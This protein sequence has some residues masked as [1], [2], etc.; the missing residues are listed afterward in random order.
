MQQGKEAAAMRKRALLIVG[1]ALMVAAAGVVYAHWTATLKVDAN[2]YTG[3]I[4]VHWKS[5]STDDDGSNDGWEGIAELANLPPDTYD[6][7]G[8]TSSDDPSSPAAATRYTKDVGR[9]KAAGAG[10]DTFTLTAENVYPS[11]Y[12]TTHSVLGNQGSVPV[13]LQSIKMK[14]ERTLNPAAPVPVWVDVTPYLIQV[15]GIPAGQVALLDIEGLS[16]DYEFLWDTTTGLWC[17]A[18][19]DPGEGDWATTINYFHVDQA[20]NQNAAY[21]ITQELTFVN[22]NEYVEPAN[23]PYC[24]STF[25]GDPIPIP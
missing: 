18:Q 6:Y 1:L 8:D 13:K 22:W 15:G 3:S 5:L 25:G 4:A 24:M 2:V 9:C 12:C 14:V 19:V 20:A 10:T 7:W 16:S 23:P 11:Y 21:R 17:G